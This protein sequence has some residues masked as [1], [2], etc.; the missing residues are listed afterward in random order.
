MQNKPIGLFG[1]DIL[2]TT[3]LACVITCIC[4]VFASSGFWAYLSHKTD[5]NDASKAML[6]GL[7]HDR[8]MELGSRYLN[9]GW[10]T[11]DEYENFHDYLYEPY[12]KLGGN[13]TAKH[14]MERV[15]RLKIRSGFDEGSEEECLQIAHTTS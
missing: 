1:G 14:M 15:D 11:A 2:D 4:S 5:K 6:K 9:R 12:V 13:G 7:G 8:I 3:L 10:L